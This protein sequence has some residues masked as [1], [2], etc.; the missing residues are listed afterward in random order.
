MNT[1]RYSRWDD[2][3]QDLGIDEES[4][5]DSLSDDILAHGDMRRALRNCFQ[6]GLQDERGQRIGGLLDLVERLR[7]QRQQQLGHYNR[8]SMMDDLKERLQ[9]SS[10]TR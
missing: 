3:Q 6:R 1:Y 9:T 4:I 10:P 5:M 8:E 2:S 7:H